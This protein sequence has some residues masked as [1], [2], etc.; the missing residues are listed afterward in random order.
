MPLPVSL[1]FGVSAPCALAPD[2]VRDQISVKIPLRV[3]K[4]KL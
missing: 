2:C 4:K 3:G 1:K